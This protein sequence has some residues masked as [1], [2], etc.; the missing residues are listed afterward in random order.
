MIIVYITAG[1]AAGLC[2]GA[3][4]FADAVIA[5]AIFAICLGSLGTETTFAIVAGGSMAYTV[6]LFMIRNRTD[7]I[8]WQQSST[9][10]WLSLFGL[11]AAI[12][13]TLCVVPLIATHLAAVNIALAVLLLLF[14]GFNLVCAP[15]TLGGVAATRSTPAI[16]ILSGILGAVAGLSG[17]FTT[18]WVKSRQAWTQPEAR[19]VY[20]PFVAV[21]HIVV[22][23]MLLVNAQVLPRLYEVIGYIAF[24]AIG[25]TFSM[26]AI[27]TGQLKATSLEKYLPRVINVVGVIA[28]LN[29]LYKA[30]CG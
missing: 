28:A 29:L 30:V 20:Q 10:L 27:M 24:A 15:I 18:L 2:V 9:L 14:C 23:V 6:N 5:N 19:G 26:V 4:G 11:I 3:L 1:F 16:G 7:W 17:V 21:M 12:P 22:L 8:S 25:L 13:T